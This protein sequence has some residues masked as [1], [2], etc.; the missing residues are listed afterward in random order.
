MNSDESLRLQRL[1]D[2]RLLDSAQDDPELRDLVQQAR[3]ALPGATIAA[4]SL[5]DEDRQWFKSI[6]GLDVTQTDRSVSFCSHT[7][8]SEGEMVVA[9]AT[10]DPRFAGNALVTAHPRIR[11]Y[12]GVKLFNDIGALCVIGPEPRQAT[13][14][15]ME[16]IRKIAR[17]V[18]MRLMAEALRN[19][20]ERA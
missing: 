4:V 15:E 14:G 19:R 1:R 13:A 3:A 10:Q 8:R 18:D 2:L 6:V 7:I 16:A 9:D 20:R 11:F 12:A 5:V 17:Y